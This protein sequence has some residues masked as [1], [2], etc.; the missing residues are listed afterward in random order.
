MT[1]TSTKSTAL[2]KLEQTPWAIEFKAGCLTSSYE[3]AIKYALDPNL[4]VEIIH[5]NDRGSWEWA[6]VAAS[7]DT[8][9]WMDTKPTKKAALVLCRLMKWKQLR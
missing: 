6:I 1:S 8:D 9:F 7:H 3:K 2:D 4:R 5:T